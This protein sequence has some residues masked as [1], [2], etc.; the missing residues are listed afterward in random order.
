MAVAAA[1]FDEEVEVFLFADGFED[2][3]ESGDV[4][5]ANGAVAGG[6]VGDDGC[7]EFFLELCDD[8]LGGDGEDGWFI[9]SDG[10]FFFH[11]MLL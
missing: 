11:R 7:F 2:F 4:V 3:E 8:F 5:V 9:E 6:P 1:G 10:A